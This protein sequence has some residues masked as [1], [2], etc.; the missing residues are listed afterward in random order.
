MVGL[1]LAHHTNSTPP[2]PR[3]LRVGVERSYRI[4]L[5]GGGD[6]E[7]RYRMRTK[8]VRE[9]SKDR[10]DQGL[11]LDLSL[12]DYRV[13]VENHEVSTAHAGGGRLPFAATGLPQGFSLAGTQGRLWLP[14]FAFFLPDAVDGET[15]V[16]AEIKLAD[17]LTLDGKGTF[18]D[19]HIV[20]DAVLK[21]GTGSAIL[22]V[23]TTFDPA[24]WPLRSEGSLV[25][26]SGTQRFTLVKA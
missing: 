11:R 17:G 26:A 19:R 9:E 3:D 13:K 8:V 24:G 4:E 25:D 5:T 12:T 22:K 2:L 18:K 10:E 20:L 14:L 1:L 6:A 21:S 23:D 16:I 15:F 7:Y